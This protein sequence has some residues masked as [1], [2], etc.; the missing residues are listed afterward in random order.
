MGRGAAADGPQKTEDFVNRGFL[1]SV[2][3]GSPQGARDG[4]D[5]SYFHSILTI[6]I[7][8]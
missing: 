3:V 8:Q 5:G 2:P 6:R 1:C 4:A 7:I